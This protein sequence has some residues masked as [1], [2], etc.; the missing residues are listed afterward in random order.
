MMARKFGILEL[1]IGAGLFVLACWG[2]YQDVAWIAQ[3]FYAYGWWSVILMVDGFCACARGHSLFTRSSRLVIPLAFWSTSFW[4]FFELLNVR[5]RNWYYVGVFALRDLETALLGGCFAVVCLSTVFI[6]IFQAIEVLSVFGLFRSIQTG[7]RTL[8]WWL[9][10]GLQVLGFGMAGLA[11]LFPYYLAPL[12]WGSF[13]F[14]VDPWNYRRGAR[15][16]LKDMEAGD[17][18]LLLRVLAAGLLCGV[19][20]ESLNF[21]APQKWIY[22]VRG[23]EGFKLFEMPLLGF[24]G[25][26]GLALDSLAAF[27][28]ISSFFY[29]NQVWEAPEDLSYRVSPTPRIGKPIAWLLYGVQPIGWVLVVYAIMGANF[30]SLEL[31]IVDLDLTGREIQ[32]LS[33][34]GIHRPRQLL[35]ATRTESEQRALGAVLGR[36]KEG[37]NRILDQAELYTFKGIGCEFGSLLEGV[38]VRTVEDLCGWD[39]VG[40]QKRLE[41]NAIKMN[42]WPP[43][44]D[45]VRVWV[46]AAQDRGVVMRG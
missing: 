16:I 7:R 40:L 6:G 29:S 11:L 1:V 34:Q 44:L 5:F 46:L 32:I 15:S 42:T 23:L 31:R 18:G 45:F 43:R 36:E 8:P 38:G 33:E 19:V 30:G 17:W 27:A 41:E 4:F 28:L 21:F 20:W 14:V 10:Y 3:P 35:R 13:T 39:P 25:F 9:S 12:I 24:L 2:L 22:T 37:M 26:P